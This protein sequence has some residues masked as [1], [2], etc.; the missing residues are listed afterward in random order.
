MKHP[1]VVRVLA[2]AAREAAL[3][4]SMATAFPAE[5]EEEQAEEDLPTIDRDTIGCR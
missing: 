1:S 5:M 2:G 3:Y 4:K